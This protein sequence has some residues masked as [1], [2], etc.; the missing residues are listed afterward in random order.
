MDDAVSF[1][2][3]EVQGRGYPKPRA[4]GEPVRAGAWAALLGKRGR[5][6]A[7]PS[8]PVSSARRVSCLMFWPWCRSGACLREGT[9]AE[10]AH[11]SAKPGPCP[12]A[13]ATCLRGSRPG[14]CA[15][16]PI[17]ATPPLDEPSQRFASQCCEPAFVPWILVAGVGECEGWPAAPTRAMATPSPPVEANAGAPRRVARVA[18]SRG[19]RPSG[20]EFS[21]QGRGRGLPGPK[22]TPARAMGAT[23][24][25]AGVPAAPPPGVASA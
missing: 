18:P 16:D 17:D 15:G 21:L 25:D 1:P 13:V 9:V 5:P 6:R 8:S 10:P 4:P 14:R 22:R 24:A 20:H 23:A 12:T 7:A 11:P 3:G 19:S 2:A